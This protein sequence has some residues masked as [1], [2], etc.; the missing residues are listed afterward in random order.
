MGASTNPPETAPSGL[1]AQSQ[2][3]SPPIREYLEMASFVATIALALFAALALKQ[4]V[5][6]KDALVVAKDDIKIRSRREAIALAAKQCE[7]FAAT[8]Q[9]I[10][11]LELEFT[12]NHV[13]IRNSWELA[14][15]NFD[16]TTLKDQKAA[17]VWI[18]EVES[19]KLGNTAN[20]ILT[21]LEAFAIYFAVGAADE[22]VAFP[23]AGPVFCSYVENLTPWLILL[24]SQTD[25]SYTSGK[26]EIGRAHV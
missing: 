2:S 8:I 11:N 18:Q 7:D 25:K 19:K 24:R 14:N 6:A 12:K 17:R 5:V 16:D 21:H 10:D 26:Y 3:Q 23:V 22:E 13:K 9:K 4:I 1:T 20:I 15:K